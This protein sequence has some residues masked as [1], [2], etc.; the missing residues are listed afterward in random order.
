[1]AG[2]RSFPIAC[3]FHAAAGIHILPAGTIPPNPLELLSAHRF[4]E[5]LEKLKATFDVILI[6][7]APLQL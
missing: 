6:D 1:V 2:K 5:L 3:S 7:S 4:D